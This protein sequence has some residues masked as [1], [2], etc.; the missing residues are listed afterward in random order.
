M[1]LLRAGAHVVHAFEWAPH[2]AAALRLSLDANGLADRCRVYDMDNCH[3]LD[4]LGPIA[5]RVSLGLTPSSR[6][7]WPHASRL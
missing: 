1:P 7:S 6:A 3:A 2:T 4:L 5:H